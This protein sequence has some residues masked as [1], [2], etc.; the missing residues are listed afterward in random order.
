MGTIIKIDD[1]LIDSK[2]F[3]V[4][5]ACDLD[6]CRGACC[7]FPGGR[8]APLKDSELIDLENS[9]KVARKYLSNR[10][11]KYI[12]KRGVAEGPAGNL[13]LS[14]IN[15]KEC[16][17]VFF[18]VGIAKC[19]IDKA[20]QEGESDFRKPISCHLFPIREGKFGNERL[21]FYDKFSECEEALLKGENENID[22]INCT[23]EGLQR[24]YG[25]GVVRKLKLV[26]KKIR[27]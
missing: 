26:S 1:I 13:A 18:E 17:F 2:I 23:Q 5:F 9:V 14:C 16:I 20:W 3:E 10:S 4:K 19:S 24:E 21:L 15:K 7:T 8:G 25:N 22:L 6:K 11:L 27:D 12:E